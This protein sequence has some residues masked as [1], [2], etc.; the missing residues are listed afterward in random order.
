M[1]YPLAHA[2]V[3]LRSKIRVRPDGCWEWL[4]HRNDRGYARIQVNGKSRPAMRVMY[5]HFVGP[6]P[7]GLELDHLCRNRACVNP[8]HA[9]AVTHREN[10][11]RGNGPTAVNARKT[12]CVQGHPFAPENTIVR[13]DGT[14]ECRVCK[15]EAGREYRRRR[16]QDPEFRERARLRTAAYRERMRT[17]AS[18]EVHP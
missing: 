9:E 18:D 2:P 12:H 13:T 16:S 15:R 5:E 4:N 6:V 1:S 7:E 8:G 11:L 17:V 14:R 10:T 3:R